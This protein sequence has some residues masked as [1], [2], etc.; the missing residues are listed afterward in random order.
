MSEEWWR[1]VVG[2]WSYENEVGSE[3]LEV[4]RQKMNFIL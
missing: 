4:G 1:E 3:C 2:V